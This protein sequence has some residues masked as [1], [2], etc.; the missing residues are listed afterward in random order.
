MAESPVYLIL[1]RTG[2]NV[3][4][5]LPN[6]PWPEAHCVP[7]YNHEHWTALFILQDHLVYGTRSETSCWTVRPGIIY[8]LSSPPPFKKR[9]VEYGSTV[10]ISLIRKHLTPSSW[11]GH[12]TCQIMAAF[13]SHHWPF[14]NQTSLVED[15]L[16]GFW[17]PIPRHTLPT[18]FPQAWSL[19]RLFA[20]RTLSLVSWLILC[21]SVHE[22]VKYN[23]D[24]INRFQD[25]ATRTVKTLIIRY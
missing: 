17:I 8:Q 1:K 13:I 7:G 22:G 2:R 9:A 5:G 14:D 4:S 11:A 19:I 18:L 16:H 3:W 20:T 15:I 10:L 21:Q 12:C 24:A 23:D 6:W 25:W